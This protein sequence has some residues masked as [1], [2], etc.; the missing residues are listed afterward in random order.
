MKAF[1]LITYL[2]RL[3]VVFIFGFVIGQESISSQA[4]ERGFMV[5]CIGERGYFWEC[6]K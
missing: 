3:L 4:F 5:K 2:F 6:E 1:D